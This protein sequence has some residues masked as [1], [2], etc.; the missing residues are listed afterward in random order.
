[1]ASAE[2]AGFAGAAAG[3]QAVAAQTNWVNQQAGAGKLALEP[4]AAERAAKHCEDEI[5]ELRSLIQEARAI[6]RIEGLGNYPDGQDLTHRFETK[7]NDGG[8]G[9]FAMIRQMQDELQKMADAYRAA[10]KDYRAIDEQH[11]Q[12]IQRGM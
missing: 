10:A 8:A 1:M 7:A 3:I 4:D 11:A 5:R 9:A 12:D 2:S 6:A